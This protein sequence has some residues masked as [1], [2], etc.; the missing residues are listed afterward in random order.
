MKRLSISI[1][2]ILVALAF[3]AISGLSHAQ[4]FLRTITFDAPPL[5][6]LGSGVLVHYYYEDSVTFTP[7]GVGDQFSRAGGRR[8][9]CL[10]SHERRHD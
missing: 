7:I 6:A 3:S 4:G 5:V 9:E 1:R 2:T 10:R 8:A